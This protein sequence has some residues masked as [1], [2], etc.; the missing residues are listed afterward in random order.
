MTGLGSR[1][2]VSPLFVGSTGNHGL[3]RFRVARP[4]IPGNMENTG[5]REG[6][7]AKHPD[8]AGAPSENKR[9]SLGCHVQHPPLIS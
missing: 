5:N 4:N 7:N 6:Q 2:T 3:P 1:P 8:E 9:Q